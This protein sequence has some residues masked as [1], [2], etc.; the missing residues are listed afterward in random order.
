MGLF[1]TNKRIDGQIGCF[2]LEDWWL[3]TFSESERDYIE[4]TYQPM[5]SAQ[6]RPLTQGRI[7]WTSGNAT[8][9]L[10]GLAG[11]LQKPADRPLARRMLDKASELAA[12]ESDV[13]A[14]HFM[15]QAQIRT[16]YKD[17]DSDPEALG[18]AIAACDK[19]IALAP[20]AAAQF[21]K[22]YGDPLPAH[23]GFKQL[24]VIREAG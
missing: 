18:M 5:G 24:C 8:Q 9:L 1:G 21:R 13:L 10:S 3:E 7:D 14:V 20:R 2:Q 11:W 23:H 17:R 12:S 16:Y 19:Q 4:A 15:Y 22:E 6:E